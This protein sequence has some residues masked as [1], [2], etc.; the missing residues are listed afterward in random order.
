MKKMPPK[1][2]RNG[3][4]HP[5][6]QA[7]SSNIG[8]QLNPH[9][10]KC[11]EEELARCGPPSASNHSYRTLRK[12]I[13]SIEQYPKKIYNGEQA[14]SLKGIGDKTAYKIDKYLKDN[15][16]DLGTPSDDVQY[17][18]YSHRHQNQYYK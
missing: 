18:S 4:Q 3:T 14:K 7:S 11:L 5:S 12:A 10:I 9:I 1:S 17:L 15:N 6:S 2:R 8:R 13:T 16:V